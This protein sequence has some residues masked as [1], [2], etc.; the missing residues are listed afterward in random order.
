MKRPTKPDPQAQLASIK[1]QSQKDRLENKFL[2][3]WRT[4]HP[5]M[6]EPVRE[7]RFHPVRK[8]KFDFAFPEVKLAIE[9][10]GGSF[11]GGGH[12]RGA[13]QKKD[14]DKANVALSL[15]WRVL[16]FSTKHLSKPADVC[17]HVNRVLCGVEIE[18]TADE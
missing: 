9:L 11:M 3:A 15:G 14:Q 7:H 8:W 10:D 17:D 5:D 2:E 18:L 6:P 4:L 16:R 1:K 12:N 13:Q